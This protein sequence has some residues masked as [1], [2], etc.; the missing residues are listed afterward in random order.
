VEGRLLGGHG[1][2]DGCGYLVYTALDIDVH[3]CR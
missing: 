1:G 3:A 2:R